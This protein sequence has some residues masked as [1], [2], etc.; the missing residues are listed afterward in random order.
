MPGFQGMFALGPTYME[1]SAV[2]FFRATLLAGRLDLGER[3]PTSGAS[4]YPNP[5]LAPGCNKATASH[6]HLK[7]AVSPCK[8]LL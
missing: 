4:P 6:M 5:V 7:S 2:S 8:H 3:L 1:S